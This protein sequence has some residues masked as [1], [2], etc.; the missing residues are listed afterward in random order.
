MN[1][2]SAVFWQRQGVKRIN[3][4]RELSLPEVIACARQLPEIEFEVFIHGA[5]CM[6]YSGRCL[7]SAALTGR[8][9]NRGD[10]AQP[11]RWSYSLLE[12]KRPG[13]Y[14]GL[15]EDQR[16]TYIFN[17]R[18]LC[19]LARL[20]E[21]SAAGVSALKIEGRMKSAYYVAVV[22]RVYRQALD[23]LAANSAWS[24]AELA[25]WKNEL[26]RVSHRRYTEAFFSVTQP[27][28]DLS[29]KK[30]NDYGWQNYEDSGYQRHWYYLGLVEQLLEYDPSTDS[31]RVELK[32]KERLEVGMEFEVITPEMTDFDSSVRQIWN[33]SGDALSV[34]HP[35]TRVTARCRGRLARF[36]ILRQPVAAGI[37]GG[38]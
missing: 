34:A 2:R 7:L 21:L 37:E 9:A 6:A 25:G 4:A 27:E 8:S 38:S 36:Q 32:V 18:D 11:C 35:G 24:A 28:C 23:R 26:T 19:L 22:T 1:R 12:E 5:M 3:L 30:R 16:G 29:G 15:E 10:C 13:E 31:S 14:L 33:E 20:P 17:S